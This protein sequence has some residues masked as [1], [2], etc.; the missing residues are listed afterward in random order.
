MNRARETLD[1]VV[2]DIIQQNREKPTENDV[3]SMLSLHGMTTGTPCRT[4]STR[5]LTASV[6]R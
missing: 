5:Y 6:Q 2:D 4:N 3:I 1:D